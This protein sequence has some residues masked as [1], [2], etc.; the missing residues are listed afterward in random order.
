V[1]AP[2]KLS[3]SISIKTG[4]LGILKPPYQAACM[5]NMICAF[6]TSEAFVN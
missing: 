5:R 3:C 4:Y 1:N 6:K 2:I